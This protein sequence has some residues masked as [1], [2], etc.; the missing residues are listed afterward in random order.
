MLG[1]ALGILLAPVIVRAIEPGHA[2]PPASRSNPASG[3]FQVTSAGESTAIVR[4]ANAGTN[5]L[6]ST[7][8]WPLAAV[9]TMAVLLA[10]SVQYQA[11]HNIRQRSP[12]DRRHTGRA[13]ARV[14]KSQH[15]PSA[16][17]DYPASLDG[18]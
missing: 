14:P 10:C 6:W 7:V 16:Y 15:W 1:L 11:F 13:D 2:P 8:K 4:P 18:R 17:V 9:L 5:E 12:A 3:A